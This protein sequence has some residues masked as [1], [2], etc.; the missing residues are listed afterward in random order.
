MRRE[1]KAG[2]LQIANE[3]CIGF[4]AFA[5]TP[6]Q[7]IGTS[8]VI[9]KLNRE[10]GVENGLVCICSHEKSGVLIDEKHFSVPQNM[11]IEFCVYEETGVGSFLEKVAVATIGMAAIKNKTRRK[12]LFVLNPLT[13]KY[14]V[15]RYLALRKC[16]YNLV[17]VVVDEGIASYMWTKRDWVHDAYTINGASIKAYLKYWWKYFWEFPLQDRMLR[18][19]RLLCKDGFLTVTENGLCGNWEIIEYYCQVL[20]ASEKKVSDAMND[21]YGDNVL[22]LTQPFYDSQQLTDEDVRVLKELADIVNACGKKVIIKPHPR[23]QSLGRYQGVCNYLDQ[24]SQG[25]S[26]ELLLHQLAKKPCLVVGYNSTALVTVKLMENIP[27][28]S[29]QKLLERRNID[30]SLRN[31]LD[32][33]GATF[34]KTVMQPTTKQEVKK[35]IQETVQF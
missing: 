33:F 22:V 19:K 21:L 29:L 4:L 16:D 2:I 20:D 7:A 28:L 1:N 24:E 3:K 15:L 9:R 17:S 5:Y 30:I 23:E 14:N 8:A 6:W 10:Y 31:T 12:T 13:P 25:I 35:L 34:Q 18:N 11:D 32:K 27:T 26:I